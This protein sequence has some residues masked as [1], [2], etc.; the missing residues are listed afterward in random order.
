MSKILFLLCFLGFS[1]IAEAQSFP[2]RDIKLEKPAD[3]K[4]TEKMALSAANFLLTTPFVEVDTDRGGALKFLNDWMTG[5]K[6]Y[7]FYLKGKASDITDDL[8]LF[9][10]FLAA[11]AKYT[12]ENKAEAANP[13]NVDKNAATLVIAYCDEPKNNFKLKKKYRKIL[14]NN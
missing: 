9:S 12:L 10:L 6:D 7:Q 11:M 13:L 14:E 4:A 2:Y 3:Y 5:T 1:C 8:N